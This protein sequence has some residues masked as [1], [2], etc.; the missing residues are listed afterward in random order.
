MLECTPLQRKPSFLGRQLPQLVTG[1]FTLDKRL[2]ASIKKASVTGTLAASDVFYRATMYKFALKGMSLSFGQ[3]ILALG[4]G[5][6]VLPL[7]SAPLLGTGKAMLSCSPLLIHY[8][9]FTS[10]MACLCS[11][12]RG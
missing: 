2:S 10:K 7:A 8:W 12:A 11:L 4:H 1:A 9:L 3:R 6:G 5:C